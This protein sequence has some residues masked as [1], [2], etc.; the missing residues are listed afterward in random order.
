MSLKW[1]ILST[2]ISQQCALVAKKTT[3]ILQCIRKNVA[4]TVRDAILSL[5]SALVRPHL[6]DSVQFWAPEFKKD[7]TSRERTLKDY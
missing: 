4:S 5:Y 7:R 6:E 3:G 1:C 2:S